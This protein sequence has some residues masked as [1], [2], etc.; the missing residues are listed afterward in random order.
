[1]LV[2]V[3][4]TSWTKVTKYNWPEVTNMK[5]LPLHKL[6][7]MKYEEI[8]DWKMVRKW[9]KSKDKYLIGFYL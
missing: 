5:V 7:E 8:I 4:V 2:A 3:V 9:A 6:I 1:M